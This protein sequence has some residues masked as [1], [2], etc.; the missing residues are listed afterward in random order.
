[1]E[2][3]IIG[4]GIAGMSIAHIL[5]TRFKNIKVNLYESNDYLGGKVAMINKEGYLQEHSPRVFSDSYINF[6]NLIKEVKIDNMETIYDK[7]T[8][9]THSYIIKKD[10]KTLNVNI[11]DLMTKLNICDLIRIGYY[12]I[13]GLIISDKRLENEYDNLKVKDILKHKKSIQIF[14][15]ISYIMGENLDVL[16]MY[17]LYKIFEYD[18]K[19]YLLEYPSEYAFKGV[20]HFKEPLNKV[21]IENW[22]NFLLKRGVN[23]HKE[24]NLV[25]GYIS[26]NKVDTLSFKT[27]DS[28]KVISTNGYVFFALNLESLSYILNKMKIETKTNLHELS[29]KT[30]NWQ[31]GIQIY[32]KN[33]LTMKQFGSFMLDTDWKPIIQSLD[34]FYEKP[35]S[36]NYKSIWSINIAN[37]KLVSKRLGKPVYKCKK[38]EILEEIIFQIRMSCVNK[39]IKEDFRNIEILDIKLWESTDNYFWNAAGTSNIRP[40]SETPLKN[41]VLAGTIIKTNY[42]SSF[43]EGAVESAF[44][45]INTILKKRGKNELKYYKHSRPFIFNIFRIIDNILYNYGLCSLFDI[46]IILFIIFN[47]ILKLKFN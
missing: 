21:L 34:N 10:C 6:Y 5:I 3:H 13:K 16:P 46:I 36:G 31:P 4:G 27:K 40:N 35:L 41:L 2:F 22:E 47:I 29:Y 18:I 25:N 19:R 32:F 43:V 23:I 9:E 45:A 14:E 44:I 33:K 38:H 28:Y 24:H 12:M 11:I 1:M 39:Y 8:D 17:K 7:M 26:N 37:N 20:R 42:W 30:L 15:Y